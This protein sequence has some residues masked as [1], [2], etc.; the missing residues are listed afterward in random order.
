M[1]Q[2]SINEKQ[3]DWVPKLPAIEF[4]INSA[5]SQSTGFVLFFLSSGCML[6][7]MTWNSA[8]ASKFL[9]IR[10]FALQKKLVLMA[11][12]DSILAAW[13]KQICDANQKWQ[14]APFQNGDLVYL[15]TKNITF[16]KGLAC[17]LVPKYIGPYKIMQD[18]GNQSF[19]LKLPLRLKQ[20]G[21]HNVFHASLLRIHHPN[22]D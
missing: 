17:K 5:H 14:L 16:T 20:W 6:H 11:T 21:V 7:S 1:L 22:D 9:S 19:R 13:V 8:S 12:H 3:N 18:F 4:A 2:Q 10:N 15:S